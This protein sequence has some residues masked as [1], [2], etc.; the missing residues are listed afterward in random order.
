M[1]C[2][3]IVRTMVIKRITSYNGILLGKWQTRKNE[4]SNHIFRNMKYGVIIRMSDAAY[5][6]T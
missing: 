1:G 5:E 2:P 4:M 6:Q 3:I